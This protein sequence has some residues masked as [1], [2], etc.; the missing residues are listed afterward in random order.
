MLDKIATIL[1][2]ST[3]MLLRRRQELG[4]VEAMNWSTISYEDL[5]SIM[6]EIQSL[7]SGIGQSRMQ[8]ALRARGLHVQ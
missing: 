7:T 5:F 4:L 2:V 1:G 3:K 6:G 8:G